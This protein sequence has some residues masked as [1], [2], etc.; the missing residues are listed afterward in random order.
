VENRLVTGEPWFRMK[1]EPGTVN[2]RTRIRLAEKRGDTGL[3]LCEPLTGK[4]HQLRIH[5][6][7]LGCK[8]MHDLFYPELAGKQEP[9]YAKPLQLLAKSLAFIDPLTKKPVL[10]SSE[11]SLEW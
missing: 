8:I 7:T 3:F 6:S 9:D 2:A 11:K 1:V 10:F 5:L 4:K